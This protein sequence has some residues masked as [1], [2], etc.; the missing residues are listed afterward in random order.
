MVGIPCAFGVIV[1]SLFKETDGGLA[2]FRIDGSRCKVWVCVKLG[3]ALSAMMVFGN[4]AAG[5]FFFFEGRLDFLALSVWPSLGTEMT[6]T[7]DP[8]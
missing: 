4:S 1:N 5:P 6:S 2:E 7:S 3:E 8:D